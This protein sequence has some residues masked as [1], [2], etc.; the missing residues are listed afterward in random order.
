M[1]KKLCW[2]DSGSVDIGGGLVNVEIVE[3][4]GGSHSEIVA[5]L[6]GGVRECLGGS[7]NRGMV[8]RAYSRLQEF[9][10]DPELDRIEDRE[11]WR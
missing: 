11:L 9:L 1:F 4:I 3:S 6:P 10:S 8:E 7:S 5:Y 2:G